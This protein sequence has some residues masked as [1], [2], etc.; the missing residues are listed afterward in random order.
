MNRRGMTLIETLAAG[1]LLA[2]LVLV[3]A[4]MFAALSVQQRAT[5]NRQAALHEAA[6]QLE[7]LT[8]VP[9]DELSERAVAD[10]QLSAEAQAALPGGELE[11]TLAE[12]SDLP[13]AKQ[14]SVAVRW[15]DATG[16]PAARV[17]LVAWTFRPPVRETTS[18]N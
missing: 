18:E 15:Q 5:L 7:R 11:I 10:A 8:V 16:M 2:V 1:A 3:S 17:E 6:N 4:Q 14:I 13:E 9:W 12:S